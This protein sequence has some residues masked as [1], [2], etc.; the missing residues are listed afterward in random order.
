M[1]ACFFLKSMVAEDRESFNIGLEPMW[2]QGWTAV[3][4]TRSGQMIRGLLDHANLL[5]LLKRSS[6]HRGG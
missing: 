2:S 3:R 6:V 4:R 1:A 5:P